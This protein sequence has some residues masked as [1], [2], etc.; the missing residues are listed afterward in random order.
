M[1]SIEQLK[2]IRQEYQDAVNALDAQPQEPHTGVVVKEAPNAG[3]FSTKSAVDVS[4]LKAANDEKASAR[5]Q[6][7][8]A[9]V[10]EDQLSAVRGQGSLIET[11]LDI[12]R[13]QANSMKALHQTMQQMLALMIA[14]Q[15]KLAPKQQG[16]AN[17]NT[18]AAEAYTGDP[19]DG[20]IDKLGGLLG[21]IMGWGRDRRGRNRPGGRNQP[22]SKDRNRPGG[23]TPQNRKD[24][25]RPGGPNPQNSNPQ[26]SRQPNR[27]QRTNSPNRPSRTRELWDNL[28]RKA[29]SAKA[30][31]GNAWASTPRRGKG[32]VISGLLMGAGAGAWSLFGDDEDEAPSATDVADI[33]RQVRNQELPAGTDAHQPVDGLWRGQAPVEG[34]W[35]GDSV[36]RNNPLYT[37]ASY[38][39]LGSISAEEESRGRASTVSSGKGDHGGV[40]YGT[41]QLSSS[42]GTMSSFLRSP[43]GRE[44]AQH[45]QDS[46]PG[47]ARFSSRFRALSESEQGGQF[48]A[49]QK[50]F[51]TR[52]H[53]EPQVKRV[54]TDT[55]IDFGSKGRGVQEML[56]STGV[57]YGP[58]SNVIVNALK[59]KNVHD[60]SDADIIRT[61]QSYK[62]QSADKY[63]RGSSPS[64]RSSVAQ[65]AQREGTK[66]LAL[67]V[68]DVEAAQNNEDPMKAA[69][70]SNISVTNARGAQG[71][72]QG[73]RAHA[74]SVVNAQTP[75]L[76]AH[77]SVAAH[78]QEQG[79]PAPFSTTTD[80]GSMDLGERMGLM[81]AGM[82]AVILNHNRVNMDGLHPKFKQAFYAMIGDW[83]QNHGGTVCCVESA[84]RTNAEQE[85]LWNKYGK[86]PKR[87]ARPGTSRHESGFAIDIDRR[88]AGAL[89]SKGLLAKYGFHRPLSNEPWHI[90]MSAASRQGPTI[91]EPDGVQVSRDAVA[92][93]SESASNEP[94]VAGMTPGMGIDSLL[95]VPIVPPMVGR[96]PSSPTST[97]SPAN[98]ATPSPANAATPSPAKAAT[99]AEVR[100]ATPSPAKAA[101]DAE[102]RVADG[103]P[104][105]TKGATPSP[106]TAPSPTKGATPSPTKVTTGAD[107]RV[108]D[109]RPSPTTQ[110]G[111]GALRAG[112]KALPVIGTV[113]TV[114]EAVNIA[115]DDSLSKEEKVAAGAELAGGVGGAI[116]GGKAGAAVGAAIGSAFFGVG[117]VPGALIGGAIGSVGG[118]IVGSWGAK[119]A[120]DAIV[121]E[122]NP[123]S[124]VVE[125]VTPAK[126]PTAS[127]VASIMNSAVNEGAETAAVTSNVKAVVST[128][129]SLTP[130]AETS[131]PSP[132]VS[133]GGA[134]A[135]LS[136]MAAAG[137]P[138]DWRS[139][140]GAE[141][142]EAR[143]VMENPQVATTPTP[144]IVQPESPASSSYYNT[145]DIALHRPTQA[146]P[147]TSPVVSATPS[148]TRPMDVSTKGHADPVEREVHNPVRSVIALNVKEQN[149]MMPDRFKPEGSR[150][151]A[152]GVS[153]SNS[154]R[155]TLDDCPVSITDGGLVLLQTGFI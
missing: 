75:L 73:P 34:S 30:A 100:V 85:A 87:V 67:N 86:D 51:V 21:D 123:E 72:M 4:S 130:N 65:R 69:A 24:R 126:P 77:S 142:K 95:S 150:I 13:D 99:D 101:T 135:L 89:D 9:K 106:T 57:Q 120:H 155:Q 82:L 81:T 144:T 38:Q 108:A 70:I 107:V 97:P 91:T 153:S 25:N 94:E 74:Q 28:R 10:G 128:A 6:A 112:S 137:I 55:G 23:P 143:R 148:A 29:S 122:A 45:F 41:H 145:T 102:V 17:N 115:T 54:S 113:L 149:T 111:K 71:L 35:A 117:A 92:A 27:N 63:F 11:Q 84:F 39:G 15:K 76:T 60:M 37:T 26:N 121:G 141:T 132:D 104:S 59:G 93:A 151:P 58:N 83:K 53:Y 116:A 110:A 5:V 52:T 131:A 147:V 109:G 79:R 118:Y 18:K 114:A 66:L 62:Q 80:E 98:A 154:S 1:T 64:V 152:R 61:V 68:R 138:E 134:T 31:A 119:E 139:T 32:A 56:Y 2:E 42:V 8:M 19:K 88:S 47:D 96:G 20:A 124:G 50:A 44:Y 16:F 90:E 133:S 78:T 48:A 12:Q 136:S 46:K 146:A 49:A 105:P 129:P 40:S 36:I 140:L 103:K 33:Q 125:N 22:N 43:E 127:E 3:R 7:R 14:Q